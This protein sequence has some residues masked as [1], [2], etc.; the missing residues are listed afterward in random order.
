MINPN[1]TNPF[2]NDVDARIRT[3][4]EFSMTLDA[5]QQEKLAAELKQLGADFQ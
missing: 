1:K 4:A 5:K 2:N 3:M